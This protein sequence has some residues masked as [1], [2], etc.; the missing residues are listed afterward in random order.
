MV[1]LTPRGSMTK[2]MVNV[3]KIQADPRL[4]QISISARYLLLTLAS[5]SNY[6]LSKPVWPTQKALRKQTGLSKRTIVNAMKELITIGLVV[7]QTNKLSSRPEYMLEGANSA[8]ARVQI[9]HF[10]DYGEIEAELVN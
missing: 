2:I 7:K 10:R 5:Y 8:P 6:K 3:K 1:M 4:Q 9:L